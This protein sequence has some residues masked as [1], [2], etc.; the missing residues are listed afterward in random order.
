[1]AYTDVDLS[2]ELEA[3]TKQAVA[4]HEGGYDLGPEFGA[5]VKGMVAFGRVGAPWEVA[6]VVS[7]LVSED[8]HWVTGLP[9]GVDGG[10]QL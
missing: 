8:E 9:F 4:I 10:L 2:T 5:M 3:L 1:M 7:F 6:S